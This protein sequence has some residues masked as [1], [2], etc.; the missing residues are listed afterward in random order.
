MFKRKDK[1]FSIKVPV[2]TLLKAQEILEKY[3]EE[4]GDNPTISVVCNVFIVVG[5]ALFLASKKGKENE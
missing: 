5:M 4:F 2:G 1:G 3:P